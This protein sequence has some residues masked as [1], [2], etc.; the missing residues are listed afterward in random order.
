MWHIDPRH[1]VTEDCLPACIRPCEHASNIRVSGQSTDQT[2]C[3][4]S[5][6]CPPASFTAWISTLIGLDRPMLRT[7]NNPRPKD[8]RVHPDDS[9]AELRV[10]RWWKG[11]WRRNGSWICLRNNC[12]L[13]TCTHAPTHTYTH[14]QRERN[15]VACT[16][17][18]AWMQWETKKSTTIPCAGTGTT[19]MR[20]FLVHNTVLSIE[21]LLLFCFLFQGRKY[22]SCSLQQRSVYTDNILPVRIR[23]CLKWISFPVRS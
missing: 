15:R 9:S 4:P 17:Y 19:R 11:R 6:P 23:V 7:I 21:Q 14:P 8:H 2:W 18:Y 1:Q 20:G 10:S 3:R 16:K 13:C 22:P 5:L 12:I